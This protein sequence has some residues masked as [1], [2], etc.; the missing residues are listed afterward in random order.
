M[1]MES[2]TQTTATHPGSPTSGVA[3]PPRRSRKSWIVSCVILLLFGGIFAYGITTRFRHAAT[4]R[5]E[6][7]QMSLPAVSV[8]TPER[9]A[10]I[11]EI[12]LP[13]NVQPFTSAPIYARTNGYLKAWYV[14]IGAHVKERTIARRD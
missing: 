14:D 1:R 6:T 13:G 2:S 7:A 10:P 4:V 5:A 12:V 3:Q 8:A 11:Q 9:S